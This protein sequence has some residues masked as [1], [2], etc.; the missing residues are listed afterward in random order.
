MV[1]AD[2]HAAAP[3]PVRARIF[4]YGEDLELGL[5]AGDEGVATW[6]WPGARVIH[7]RAHASRKAFGGE[8]FALLAAQRRAVVGQLRGPRAA[9]LD[10]ALQ[11]V[12]FADRAALKALARRPAARERRQIAG[13][14]RRAPA[15]AR[16]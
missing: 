6:W 12:T 15:S 4:L 9:R 14:A 7:H 16:G 5:R 2:G 8:P 11:L 13:P 3:G 1:A 10:D